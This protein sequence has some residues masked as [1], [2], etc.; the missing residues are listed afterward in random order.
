MKATENYNQYV[1]LGKQLVK[2]VEVYQIKIAEYAIA[3]CDI[4][5]GG[6][7]DGYYTLINYAD[8]IGVARKTLQNWVQ[9]Y[10][11]VIVKLDTPIKTAEEFSKVRKVNDILTLQTTIENKN[12]GTNN[13]RR[14]IHAPKER[15]QSLYDRLGDEEKPF[16]LELNRSTQSVKHVLFL[17]KTRDL[18][19][20]GDS[21]L[22]H[23]ME[24]LD[25][26]SEIIN[27]HLTDKK[28]KISA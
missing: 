28:R 11:N 22:L 2:K 21:E 26:A 24:I 17:M 8:D 12:S 14:T 10:R 4:R 27:E 16:V 18:N 13:T 19:I 3:V 6:R 20:V 7:S 25:D 15:V 1:E 9:L 23:L 5:H